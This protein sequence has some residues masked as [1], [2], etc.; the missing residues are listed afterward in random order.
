[1]QEQSV[2]ETLLSVPITFQVGLIIALGLLF[3]IS[4]KMTQNKGFKKQ[5]LQS[6][7]LKAEVVKYLLNNLDAALYLTN[8][9]IRD[10]EIVGIYNTETIILGFRAINKLE[11]IDNRLNILEDHQIKTQLSDY[12]RDIKQLLTNAYHMENHLYEY[13][14]RSEQIILSYDREFNKLNAKEKTMEEAMELKR[15]FKKEINDHKQMVTTLES[16]YAQQRDAVHKELI[17]LNTRNEAV[18]DLLEDYK[19]KQVDAKKFYA[20]KLVYA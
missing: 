6:K 3:L 12:I 14:K 1:M 7:K 20:S 2:W 15:S 13:K 4:I 9:T 11:K 17:K 8:K 5:I 16:T 10:N 18:Q 19:R